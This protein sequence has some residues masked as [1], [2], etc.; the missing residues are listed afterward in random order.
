MLLSVPAA[1]VPPRMRAIP[2]VLGISSAEARALVLDAPL[3]LLKTQDTLA[4]GWR[5]LRRAAALRP[6]WREQ[7]GSKWSP[8]TLNRCDWEHGSVSFAEFL[9]CHPLYAA[10]Q[11]YRGV[12]FPKFGFKNVI[13]GEQVEPL[14]P[15]QV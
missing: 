4:L 10:T 8:S 9:E 7:I 1:E 11:Y 15:Q 14:H 2:A 5:E 3:L 12:T 6:E 13:G